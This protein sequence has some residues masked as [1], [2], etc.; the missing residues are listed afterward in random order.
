M[1]GENI[2]HYKI[3]EKIG[4]GGMGI[5]YKALDLNLD[6]IV[7]LKFL[8]PTLYQDEEAK[9]RFINEAKA[10]SSLQHQ[11]ICTIHEID[12]TDDGQ[13][14]I[15]MDC[16]EGQTLKQKIKSGLLKI[17]EA[18]NIS[19]QV[20]QGLFAAHEKGI[21][22][23]DIKPA[24][25]F[26]TEKNEVKIL[27]F[28][29]AKSS[30]HTKITRI[31]STKGT[32]AYISPEQAMGKEAT[33][34]SDIWSLGVVMY[35]MLTGQLPFKGDVDQVMIYSILDK[36]P[37]KITD[38]NPEIPLELENIVNK[39][40]EK[41]LDSR[42]QNI[43]EMLADLVNF[44]NRSMGLSS[45]HFVSK[46]K[47]KSKKLKTAIVS[48]LIVCAAAVLFYFVN[49][50]FFKSFKNDIPI[51]IAV[52]GFE[53]QT[54]DS[55]YNYLQTAIPNLL[56]TNLEQADF[57]NVTTW[58]RMHDLLKQIGKG[59]VELIDKD[60][61][62]QICRMD[63]IDAIVFG[64]FVKAGDVFVTDVKVLD[65]SNKKLLKSANTRSEGVQSI[66]E[67]QIDYLSDEIVKGIG[68]SAEEIESV[69]LRIADVTT[70][71]MEAYKYFLSG[72]EKWEKDYYDDACRLLEKAVELD[73]TF[74]TAYLYLAYVYANLRYVAKEEKAFE[75][76][77]AFSEKA[78]EK[79]RLYIEADYA[80]RIENQLETRFNILKEIVKKFPKEKEAYRFLGIYF[81]YRYRYEEAINNFIKALE[82]DP[83]YSKAYNSLAYTYSDMGD[84]E[85][86]I[87]YFKKFMALSPGDAGP[88]DSMGDLYFKSG[89]LDKAI[90]KYKEALEVKPG[91]SSGWAIAYIYALKENY[92]EAMRWLDSFIASNPSPG[93]K[94]Q[95]YMWKGIYNLL[96]GNNNRSLSDFGKSKELMKLAGNEYGVVV[97]TMLKGWI[98]LETPEYELSRSC[99]EEFKVIVKDLDYLFDFIAGI[100]FMAR[101][102]LMEGKIDSAKSKLA[103]SEVL[104]HD[105]SAMGPYWRA[106]I[107]RNH[108]S[109]LMEIMLADGDFNEAIAE[110]EKPDSSDKLSM[111]LKQL[112]VCNMPFLQDI[113]ARAYYLNGELD[114]AIAEYQ[115]LITFDPESKDR[116][117][118]HPKY[119]YRLAKLY[120]EKGWK[121]KAISELEKFLE[122]WKD[123]DK[124]LP[125]FIDANN[126]LAK[127]LTVSVK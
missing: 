20:S 80:G 79:E 6:R 57:L 17:D 15:C 103:A 97:A 106:H 63:G 88:L 116:R 98:Y 90:T 107:K 74:A 69:Q 27:D 56:I 61:A 24:N 49:P 2:S 67:S 37:E 36:E 14:F 96:L 89:D 34:Q 99:F 39:A 87:E 94:A 40:L 46:R 8:P 28:G 119:H 84:Y 18:L 86:A 75:R 102:D 126:R 35:E 3:L 54:G 117:L 83:E 21:I 104:M 76:A 111:G 48:A 23:R 7:A 100:Q 33:H 81:R 62:F 95:G 91:F 85:K 41:N 108:N 118:I 66:L 58:E 12:E 22:H 125:E 16:Y 31:D 29:L 13:L 78:T 60:L 92:T 122:L 113:L 26:I 38:L 53:N 124:E 93:K 114:K 65:A 9:Q 1:I 68:I 19:I 115:R 70:N 112:I 32:I 44:K 82:L 110:G 10:A 4:G 42:Y 51:S 121:E 55:S 127:L 71:S 73:S 72:K 64:S 109:L 43:E 30:E 123:A 101:I 50:N 25:I 45:S 52:I 105:L 47:G 5:I 77:K 59:E 120:E 11:N